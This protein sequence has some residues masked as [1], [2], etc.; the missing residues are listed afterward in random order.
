MLLTWQIILI[1]W[2]EV[3]TKPINL[4]R[5]IEIIQVESF[6]NS[7]KNKNIVYPR[8]SYIWAIRN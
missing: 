5:S 7:L 6:S 3:K 8:Q 4:Q 1:D 2:L